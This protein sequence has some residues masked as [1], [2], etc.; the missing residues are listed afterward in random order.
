MEAPSGLAI[1]IFIRMSLSMSASNL[2]STDLIHAGDAFVLSS[3][4]P[5]KTASPRNSDNAFVERRKSEFK[6]RGERR[7]FGSSHAELTEPGREL[8]L[9]IDKYKVE[10]H[11][12]YITC[13]EMLTVMLS[14]GYSR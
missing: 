4:T 2:S 6:A 9:A 5:A 10:H 7:Q 11:R 14:L 13:D 8:A 3:A 12:R 1:D